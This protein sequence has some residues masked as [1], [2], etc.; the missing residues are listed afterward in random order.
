MSSTP[1]DTGSIEQVYGSTKASLA[2]V[3]RLAGSEL[4]LAAAALLRAA[5]LTVL[6]TVSLVAASF[7]AMILVA[8]GLVWLG[9][10]WPA[11]AGVCL[12]LTVT[13]AI[14]MALSAKRLLALCQWRAT[15]VQLAALVAGNGGVSS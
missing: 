7:M 12:L 14:L 10:T 6:A 5:L 3:G 9:L 11:A 8:A 4:E 15:R 13:A 1:A 2:A